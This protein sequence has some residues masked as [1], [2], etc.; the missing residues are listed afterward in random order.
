MGAPSPENPM[1]STIQTFLIADLRGYTRFTLEQGDEAAARL[2]ARFALI[3]RTI[4]EARGGKVIELRGD[5]VLAVF[6]SARQALWAA[7]E[8]E[9]GVT[10]ERQADPTFPPVGIGLDAGEA[11]SV[12]E[13]YRGAALNLAA[14]LCSLA[15][16]GEVLASETV[17]HLAR[18][19]LRLTYL[20]RGA[21]QLKGFADPVQVIQVR[22]EQVPQD[23]D[24]P[25]HFAAL[26]STETASSSK[27]P[28]LPIGG[29]LGALPDGPLVA[30]DNELQRI[31]RAFAE[32]DGGKGQLILLAAEPGVGKTRLAQEATLAARNHGWRVATGRCYEAQQ[33]AAYYPFREALSVAFQAASP[34]LRMEAM[35]RWPDL[36]RLLPGQRAD[37]IQTAA[38][39]SKYDEQQRLFWA[40]TGFVQEFARETSLLLAVDDLQWADEA[41]LALFQHLANHTRN[42]RVLLLGAYRDIEVHRRHPLE[43]VLRTLGREHL[44]ERIAVRRMPPEGTAALV[45]ATLDEAASHDLADLIHQRTD[46]NPFLPKK[47][48]ASWPSARMSIVRARIGSSGPLRRSPYLKVCAPRSANASHG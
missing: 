3:A 10:G 13:G 17:I 47:C 4:V 45:A 6:G 33:S 41:S 18:K 5:E 31:L 20:E 34:S 21:M 36:S 25:E 9:A 11:V 38:E 1:L 19:V 23:N 22:V 2:A 43:A 28:P 8:L 46:G 32:V 29:F 27:S 35:R 14:R 30:R 24:V 26:A 15:G 7:V 40:V 37:V 39:E 48:C 16:P 12:E 44:V 42:A